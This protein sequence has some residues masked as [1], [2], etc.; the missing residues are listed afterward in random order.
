MLT[1]VDQPSGLKPHWGCIPPIMAD[2]G[3]LCPKGEPFFMKGR[4]T[5]SLDEV[6]E[7][8]GKSAI[9]VCEMT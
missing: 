1:I 9:V 2:M 4:R 8:I 5:I 7:R 6:Y 3:I